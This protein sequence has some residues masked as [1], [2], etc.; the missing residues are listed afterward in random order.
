MHDPKQSHLN[1]SLHVVRYLKGSPG[2]GILLTNNIDDILKA[3]CDSDWASYVVTRKLVEGYGINLGQS[4][5]SQKL[6]NKKPSPAAQQKLNTGAW[7]LL[8]QI[9]YGWSDSSKKSI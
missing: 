5:I 1:I 3:F 9:L 4:L 6:K 2:L 7:L 8:W